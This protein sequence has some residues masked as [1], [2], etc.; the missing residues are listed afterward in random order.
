MSGTTNQI[1]ADIQ[2]T[3]AYTQL[4]ISPGT[5]SEFPGSLFR[6]SEDAAPQ[7]ERLGMNTNQGRFLAAVPQEVQAS[8]AR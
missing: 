6:R 1:S 7:G 4:E 3:D 2:T 5:A 8:S